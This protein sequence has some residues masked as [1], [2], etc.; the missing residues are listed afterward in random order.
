MSGVKSSNSEGGINNL[1]NRELQVF[2]LL[3]AGLSTRKVAA[4]LGLSIKTVETH[5]ENIKR[6]LGLN[7]ASEL[8]HF[9]NE[10]AREQVSVPPQMLGGR[11]VESVLGSNVGPSV[12]G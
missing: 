10:W 12:T 7:G 8:I 2:Q 5:R 1:S 11:D 6:K 3:G 9:A 4:K